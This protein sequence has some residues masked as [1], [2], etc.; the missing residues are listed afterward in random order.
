MVM[1][2]NESKLKNKYVRVFIPKSLTNVRQTKLI[3]VSLTKW[4]ASMADFCRLC[5]CFINKTQGPESKNKLE[6]I[7]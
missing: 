5:T 3:I 2:E 7:K 1:V 4:A 6:W